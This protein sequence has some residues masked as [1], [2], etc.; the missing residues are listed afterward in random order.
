M[1]CPGDEEGADPVTGTAP[2]RLDAV[3]AFQTAWVARRA[4]M[5]EGVEAFLCFD[6]CLTGAELQGAVSYILDHVVR[7][8]FEDAAG[9]RT[10]ETWRVMTIDGQFERLIVQSGLSLTE[11]GHLLD[12]LNVE[13]G[14]GKHWSERT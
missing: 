10:P 7:P 1:S 11:A 4:R 8:E 6:L 9:V 3:A 12:R 2:E 5:A 13:Q 14:F